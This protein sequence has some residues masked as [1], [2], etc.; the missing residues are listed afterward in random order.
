MAT[1]TGDHWCVLLKSA[2]LCMNSTVKKSHSYTP[3]QVMW[4]RESRYE[5]L[6]PALDNIQVSHEED[7]NFNKLYILNFCLL[8]KIAKWMM[9]FLLFLAITWIP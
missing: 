3:F 9:C 6:V 8:R 4:G 7:L 2:V 1:Q 5:D